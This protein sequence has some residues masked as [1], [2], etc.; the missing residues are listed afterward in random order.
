MHHSQ[1][2]AV[3]KVAEKA[4]GEKRNSLWKEGHQ[5]QH[6]FNKQIGECL[7]EVVVKVTKR[8]GT[9]S[10]LDEAK[11]AFDTILTLICKR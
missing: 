11:Q 10:A 7:N 9:E 4:T 6:S 5:K 8:P 3:W 2:G 1:G